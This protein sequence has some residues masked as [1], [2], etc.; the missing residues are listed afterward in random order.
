MRDTDFLWGWCGGGKLLKYGE[1]PIAQE[2]LMLL[3]LLLMLLLLT[4]VGCPGA[5]TRS[6]AN[7]S[8]VVTPSFV[9]ASSASC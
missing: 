1:R 6:S 5:K 3:L 9:G 2:G 8:R 7:P 4:V